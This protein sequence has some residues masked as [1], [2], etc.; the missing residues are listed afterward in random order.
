MEAVFHRE[1]QGNA[2]REGVRRGDKK[3]GLLVEV[4]A[5]PQSKIYRA[6]NKRPSGVAMQ[7][8]FLHL[9]WHS[10]QGKVGDTA[11][12]QSGQQLM[13]SLSLPRS[14]CEREN[15]ALISVPNRSEN[16]PRSPSVFDCEIVKKRG[17]SSCWP[18]L[19]PLSVKT[20]SVKISRLL[21][22][23]FQLCFGCVYF[24]VFNKNAFGSLSEFQAVKVTDQFLNIGNLL[25]L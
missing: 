13:M 21:M 17:C 10:Q 1:R 9:L 3:G 2:E 24:P 4:A 11:S 19:T 7:T 22:R 23:W 5:K 6:Q 8:N 25:W 15:A 20:V 16:L 18:F 12:R 14:D